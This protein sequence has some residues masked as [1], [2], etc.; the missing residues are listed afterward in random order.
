MIIGFM[1]SCLDLVAIKPPAPD[2]DVPIVYSTMNRAV[3]DIDKTNKTFYKMHAANQTSSLLH[4][5]AYHCLTMGG[6]L[7]R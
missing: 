2:P 3:V 1:V 5:K 6:A 7:W 4:E